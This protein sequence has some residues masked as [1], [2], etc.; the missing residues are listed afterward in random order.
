MVDSETEPGTVQGIG[1]IFS[2]SSVKEKS[3]QR[4]RKIVH[5]F[6][7]YLYL[8]LLLACRTLISREIRE[9]LNGLTFVGDVNPPA[10]KP[11]KLHVGK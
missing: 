5:T 4:T 2:K 1:L 9:K 10:L 3:T 8:L 6:F 11:S 7:W